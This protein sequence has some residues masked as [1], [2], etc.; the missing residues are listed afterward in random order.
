MTVGEEPRQKESR[1]RNN[2][3][4]INDIWNEFRAGLRVEWRGKGIEGIVLFWPADNRSN[5]GQVIVLFDGQPAPISV[6][7]EELATPEWFIG[8]REYNTQVPYGIA[9]F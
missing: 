7:P 5:C 2:P 3:R 8:E 4:F 9:D 6:P 1:M